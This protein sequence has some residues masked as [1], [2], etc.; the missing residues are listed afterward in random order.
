[1]RN[2]TLT[3]RLVSRRGGGLSAH[4]SIVARRRDSHPSHAAIAASRNPYFL[5]RP[6]GV[7]PPT[8]GSEVRGGAPEFRGDTP[9]RDS[10]A[11]QARDFLVA[12]ARGVT[13]AEA[14][15]AL[16]I[17]AIELGATGPLVARAL[18]DDPGAH[19]AAVDLA[20]ALLEASPANSIAAPTSS[21]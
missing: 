20:A 16:V 5:A 10:V 3:A 8:D 13:S 18:G 7:E 19:A 6:E 17:A 1:M 11:T 4:A 9:P 14:R 2:S 21:R 12:A 15:R